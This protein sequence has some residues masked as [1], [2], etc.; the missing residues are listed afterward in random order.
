MKSVKSMNGFL[1]TKQ[2]GSD[3]IEATDA[4]EEVFL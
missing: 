2:P 4:E 3:M 1:H